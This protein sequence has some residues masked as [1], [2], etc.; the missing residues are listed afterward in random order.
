MTNQLQS[1]DEFITQL[2]EE[3]NFENINIEV[4]EQIRQDL[5]GRVEDRINAEILGNMPP[6]KLEEFSMLLD[7]ADLEKIQA[8]CQDNISNLEEVIA[9]SLDGFR[10]TYLNL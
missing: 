6:E 3:K 4:R 5:M 8:F 9:Y 2:I 7:G 10:K 1:L